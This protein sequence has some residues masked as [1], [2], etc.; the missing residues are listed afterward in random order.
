MRVDLMTHSQK[1]LPDITTLLL[2]YRPKVLTRSDHYAQQLAVFKDLS[3]RYG[4]TLR[5]KES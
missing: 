3:A 2:N 5:T 4:I 1:R